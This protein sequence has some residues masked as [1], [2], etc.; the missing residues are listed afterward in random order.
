MRA[1][2][3]ATPLPGR[4]A[5]DHLTGPVAAVRARFPRPGRGG[6]ARRGPLRRSRR[7]PGAAYRRR[8][9]RELPPPHTPA[10]RP[11][12][13]GGRR[14]GPRWSGDCARAAGTGRTAAGRGAARALMAATSLVSPCPRRRARHTES[15][16]ERGALHGEHIRRAAPGPRR[17]GG[18]SMRPLALPG[19]G[20]FYR[21]GRRAAF[22]CVGCI[23]SSAVTR[24]ASLGFPAASPSASLRAASLVGRASRRSLRPASLTS[25]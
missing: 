10:Q 6:G 5:C 14:N 13:P 19:E 7:R 17:A 21:A 4:T 2:G 20:F 9:A 22:R 8:R 1:T 15:G 18:P 23:A 25:A 16:T 3:P 12:W 11:A 24:G